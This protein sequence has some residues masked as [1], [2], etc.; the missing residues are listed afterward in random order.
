MFPAPHEHLVRIDAELAL[1]SRVEAAL[2]LRLGQTLEVLG[3]GACFELGFSSLAAYALERCERS[4]RWVEEARCLARRL[5]PLPVLRGAL[6]FGVVS[7]RK[8]VLVAR[9]ATPSDEARWTE[10]AERLTV[11]Q[12]VARL[13][14]E[15]RQLDTAVD[16]ADDGSEVCTLVCTVDREEA[17]LF[18]ATRALL[19]QLGTGS[20]DEQLEALLAE[21]QINLLGALP[22][23]TLELEAEPGDLAQARWREQLARWRAEAEIRC[24]SHL[25]THEEE[26]GFGRASTT[27]HSAAPRDTDG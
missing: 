16:H 8:A 25:H 18:E 22:P 26:D 12:L 2:R 21:A 9:V 27:R 19:S 15:P 10:I 13:N 17:W 1:Q 7:W 24:E 11:R 6:A 23:G 14:E 5:E 3:R 20:T 4:T